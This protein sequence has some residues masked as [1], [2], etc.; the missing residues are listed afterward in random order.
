M[1]IG[2]PDDNPYLGLAMERLEIE[3]IDDAY[4]PLFR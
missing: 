1:T 4:Y 3:Q 2:F